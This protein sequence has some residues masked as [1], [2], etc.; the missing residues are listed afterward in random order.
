MF[1]WDLA[2]PFAVREFTIE[3]RAVRT[4]ISQL[5][6]ARTRVRNN[7]DSRSGHII[8]HHRRHD[9]FHSLQSIA[10]NDDRATAPSAIPA[11]RDRILAVVVRVLEAALGVLFL[12]LGVTKL[13]GTD[14]AN[15]FAAIGVGRAMRIGV[16]LLELVV[17]TLLFAR[18]ADGV[19][20]ALIMAV[21]L[22]EM[23]ILKRPPI[24]VF[25]CLGTHGLTTWARSTHERGR[26]V[27]TR[28]KSLVRGADRE[29]PWPS[30]TPMYRN[31]RRPKVIGSST[32]S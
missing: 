29:R 24:A 6:R 25:A 21:A 9:V 23:G 2:V 12:Y 18:T 3:A 26:A 1:G 10:S 7:G 17:S 20:N 11:P 13:L 19:L 30:L 4:G 27:R 16:A 31:R 32:K 5:A 28:V 22:I 15:H 8:D 14:E